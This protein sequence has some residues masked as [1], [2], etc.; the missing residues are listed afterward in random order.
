[1]NINHCIHCGT[2]SE[3]TWRFCRRCGTALENLEAAA[4]TAQCSNC[5]T[6]LADGWRFCP[7]CGTGTD[8][9]SPVDSGGLSSDEV[10]DLIAAPAESPAAEPES[11]TPSPPAAPPTASATPIPEPSADIVT[12]AETPEAP[13]TEV[14]PEKV[15]AT[16]PTVSAPKVSFEPASAEPAETPEAPVTEVPPEKVAA[17]EPTVS[18]PKVSF[19]PA[20]AEPAEQV[21]PPPIPS[22]APVGGALDMLTAPP[23]P[24][25]EPSFGDDE[26]IAA[27]RAGTEAPPA[28]RLDSPTTEFVEPAVSAP[29]GELPADIPASEAVI[30]VDATPSAP[31]DPFAGETMAAAPE[32]PAVIIPPA[33]P[34]PEIHI[35]EPAADTASPT[36]RPRIPK[37]IGAPHEQSRT[38]IP[39]PLGSPPDEWSPE[40]VAER[41]RVELSTTPT[42]VTDDLPPIDGRTF[43]NPGLVGQGVQLTMLVAAGLAVA[44]I[45]AFTVLNNRLDGYATTGESLVRV[46]SAQSII[47]TWM[48][49]LL[50]GALLVAY[51]AAVLWARRVLRNILVFDKS[52]PETALW[53]WVIPGANIFVLWQHLEL[54][55]K[56]SDV[57]TK[58]DPQWRK[59]KPNWWSF[60]FALLA[61][62][63]FG[64]IIFAWLFM[65]SE[66]F[67]NAIDANAVS[68]IGY[69]LLAASL[70]SGVRAVG[71]VVD[72]QQNR[73]QQYD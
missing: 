13:V 54:A 10:A 43:S 56:G 14:P 58:D 70:L 61:I 24:P 32:P 26:E 62:I 36:I 55:W 16:E 29:S 28:P 35:P 45:V 73:V 31:V 52:V 22:E 2:E 11:L 30:D 39:R 37:P 63:A 6:A 49:P 12:P 34:E 50:I 27:S 21:E 17:T 57:F 41:R 72:R 7:N 9:A 59:G 3:P 40:P 47:N 5:S 68:I 23:A 33:K 44:M 67:E 18:A 38:A 42:T 48:R 1:M 65:S 69:G 25:A 8:T 20:S 51:V 71:T 15:A 53:M 19:E 60:G 4:K 64:V 46:E 66:T